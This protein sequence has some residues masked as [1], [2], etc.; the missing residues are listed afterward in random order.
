M[1]KLVVAKQGMAA[2]ALDHAPQDRVCRVGN[3]E[4]AWPERAAVSDA[5]INLGQLTRV[6][7]GLRLYGA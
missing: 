4:S 5:Y 2:D 1:P 3:R 6:A 7:L